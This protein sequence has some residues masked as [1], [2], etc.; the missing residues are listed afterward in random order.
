[1]CFQQENDQTLW[2]HHLPK[3]VFYSLD[4]SSRHSVCPVPT[5]HRPRDL[6][7]T[8]LD[9]PGS[10]VGGKNKGEEREGGSRGRERKRKEQREKRGGEERR[11]REGERRER[12]GS[13]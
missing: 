13:F 10:W 6:V 1:M 9:S 5:T 11:E 3:A 7:G 4:T 12:K 2:Y 8:L